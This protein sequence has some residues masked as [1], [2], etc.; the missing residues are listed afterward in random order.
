LAYDRDVRALGV[1]VAVSCV[2]CGRVGF[3]PYDGA[4]AHDAQFD[5]TDAASASCSQTP[6][7]RQVIANGNGQQLGPTRWSISAVAAQKATQA[8]STLV[9]CNWHKTTVANDPI[10][11][12]TDD[13]NDVYTRVGMTIVGDTLNYY[14]AWY[15]TNAPAGI[16]NWFVTLQ[17]ADAGYYNDAQCWEYTGLANAPAEQ[18]SSGS[19]TSD[20]T[21]T[22]TFGSFMA[23]TGDLILVAFN[24]AGQQINA[25][26][27]G[28]TLSPL[29]DSSKYESKIASATGIETPVAITVT[30]NRQIAT[31]WVLG[32]QCAP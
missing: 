7:L 27:A 4:L 32:F 14:D 25:A 31:Y 30:A 22:A 6:T 16:R 28:Y 21:S 12:F 8:G 2:G 29:V 19:T 11:M 1:V 23:H 26:G 13:K 20:A 9:C 5:A 15:L 10:T 17:T 24:Q 3:D 18:A